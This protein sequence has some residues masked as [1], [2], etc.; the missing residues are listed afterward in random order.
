MQQKWKF[1]YTGESKNN[2]K[3]ASNIRAKWHFVQ[4][5]FSK[6]ELILDWFFNKDKKLE[7]QISPKISN[8]QFKKN[9]NHFLAHFKSTYLFNP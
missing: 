1:K 7:I 4:N 6:I 8:M 5:V 3:F 2:A 9:M